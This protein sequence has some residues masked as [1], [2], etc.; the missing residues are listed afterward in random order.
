M[1]SSKVRFQ[2]KTSTGSVELTKA[3]AISMKL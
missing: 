1:C 3:N 2:F